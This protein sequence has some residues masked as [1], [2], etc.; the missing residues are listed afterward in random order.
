MFSPMDF[1]SHHFP[2]S[3]RYLQIELLCKFRQFQCSLLVFFL[4]ILRC[5]FSTRWWLCLFAIWCHMPGMFINEVSIVKLELCSL[6][7][8]GLLLRF[9]P[10]SGFSCVL[11]TCKRFAN[12]IDFLLVDGL[13]CEFRVYIYTLCGM[14][15]A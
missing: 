1:K 9:A 2:H 13:R 6:M 4:R 10:V 12:D 5:T 7:T 11:E 3:I 15:S 8:W 14:L